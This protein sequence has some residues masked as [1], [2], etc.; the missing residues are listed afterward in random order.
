MAL[1]IFSFTNSGVT[2]ML[3]RHEQQTNIELVY[4]RKNIRKL[5]KEDVNPEHPVFLDICRLIYEYRDNIYK[6][7]TSKAVRVM[8]LDGK[9]SNEEIATELLA[10]LLPIQEVSP[11]Q[12]LASQIGL[13]LGYD[14]ILDGVK[15]GAELIA[16]CEHSGAYTIYRHTDELNETGTLSVRSNFKLDDATADLIAKTKFLPPMLCE[17]NDWTNNTN[18]G[19]LQGSGSCILGGMNHH[20]GDQS[21]DVLNMLQHIPWQLNELVDYVEKSNKELDTHDKLT[22]FELMKNQSTVVYNELMDG[23]NQFYFEWNNDSRG[24]MYSQGYHLH[25]QSTQ[26]KKAI[27]DFYDE[28]LITG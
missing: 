23:G 13:A 20:N 18:G 4:S 28:E 14:N 5:V 16:V 10:V 9:I 19:A 11:I 17:P 7:Y 8:E 12:S 21:L 3:S 2:P 27:L 25:L 6:Y 26:Y 1:F 22:Q 24:R 15:T